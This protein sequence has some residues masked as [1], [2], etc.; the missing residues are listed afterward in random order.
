MSN[1]VP[2][3]RSA[4]AT[5]HEGKELSA[6]T[7]GGGGSGGSADNTIH[8]TRY[9]RIPTPY[10]IRRNK[11]SSRQDHA[12]SGVCWPNPPQTPPSI[13]SRLE[14]VSRRNQLARWASATGAPAHH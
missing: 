13:R 12:G 1:H 2:T 6:G 14:R 8:R 4:T 11:K 5:F 7:T 10:I 9:G 3:Y